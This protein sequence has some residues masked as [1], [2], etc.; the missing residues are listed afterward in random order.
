MVLSS[1]QIFN[2]PEINRIIYRYKYELEEFE[3]NPMINKID[4]ICE[5][6]IYYMTCI[7]TVIYIGIYILLL[8]LRILQNLLRNCLI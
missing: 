1:I 8:S 3:H 4:N 6:F 2:I 7:A 5:S